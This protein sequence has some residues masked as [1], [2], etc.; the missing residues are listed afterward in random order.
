MHKFL[1]KPK[2]KHRTYRGRYR[3]GDNPKIHEV[4][5]YTTVKEVAEKRLK[6]IYEDAQREDEGLIPGKVTR[7]AMKRPL[8]ELFEEF[9][10]DVRKREKSKDYMDNLRLRFPMVLKFATGKH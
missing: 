8:M 3:V 6:E 9:I 10:E 1:L 2:G 4:T 7:Q 5:L